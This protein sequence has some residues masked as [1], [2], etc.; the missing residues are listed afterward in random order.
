M[1]KVLKKV[2]LAVLITIGVFVLVV[3]G[4]LVYL[5][6]NFS[7]NADGSTVDITSDGTQK[8]TLDVDG[9]YTALTYNIGFGAYDQSY[10]CFMDTGTMADGSPTQGTHAWATSEQQMYKD[11]DGVRQVIEENDPDF[12]CI[13]EVD[14]GSDRTFGTDQVGYLTSQLAG[15]D[16]TYALNFH[17]AYLAYPFNEPLGFVRGGLLTLSRYDIEQATWGSYPIDMSFITKFTD[18]RQPHRDERRQTARAGQQPYVGV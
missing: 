3:G 12:C 7:R 17:T 18:H 15:Y 6:V 13:Q 9:T 4:Y 1:K 16:H 11:L 8:Q 10:T 14:Q 5:Q 2:L